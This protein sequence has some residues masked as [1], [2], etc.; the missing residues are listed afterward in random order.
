MA[1]TGSLDASR[2]GRP[3]GSGKLAAFADRLTGWVAAQGDITMPELAAKLKAECGVTAHP[4]SLS[5]FLIKQGF[6]IKKNAAGN[7]SRSR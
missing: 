3:P 2:Q 1:L 6:S 7:R 4:A 5:K